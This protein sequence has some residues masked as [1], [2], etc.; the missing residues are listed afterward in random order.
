[1]CFRKRWIQRIKY[2]TTVVNY[3]NLITTNKKGGNSMTLPEI[4]DLGVDANVKMYVNKEELKSALNVDEP[5]IDNE[6]LQ[7]VFNDM[8]LDER[9]NELIAD[10]HDYII[11]NELNLDVDDSEIIANIMFKL[12]KDF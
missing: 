2:L 7:N 11:D 4:K 12:E 3:D 1:M 10:V 9:I 8:F 6:A 5:I